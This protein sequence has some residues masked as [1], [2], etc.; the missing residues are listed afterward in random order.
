M[1]VRGTERVVDMFLSG[2]G[3]AGVEMG[4]RSR[5]LELPL[6]TITPNPGQPRKEFDPK[7]IS[8]LAVSIK[9]YGVLQPIGVRVIPTGYE[10]VFGERRW[11]AANEADLKTIPCVIVPD[12]ADRKTI[13]LIEN[14]HRQDL[15]A[16]EKAMAIKDMMVDENLS[17]EA[18]GKKLGL[19]KTRVHQLLN[20]LNL[21]EEMLA[22]FCR[23]DLNE[24]H[25]RALLLLKSYPEA[26]KELF[27]D[28]LLQGLT[29]NQA[30]NRAE[31]YISKIP[32]KNPVSDMV[33][34]S[35]SKLSKVEK[36]W[37]AMSHNEREDCAKEL[38]RLR[39]KIDYL[40]GNS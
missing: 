11:R 22:N 38:M 23:A 31:E 7:K 33:S 40:L 19:G 3:K 2:I 8:E 26:Q 32:V 29:G 27:Q 30:L 4:R 13:A 37:R 6:D 18:V 15:S 36:N 39:E 28:I 21:P 20:I 25:A 12:N 35:I 16:M 10:I 14:I 5:T 24:T 9:E 1:N 34:R 17:L